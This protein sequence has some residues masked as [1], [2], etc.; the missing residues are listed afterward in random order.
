MGKEKVEKLEDKN[1][2]SRSLSIRYSIFAIVIELKLVSFAKNHKRKK[3][4][5]S[6][7]NRWIFVYINILY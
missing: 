7:K 3:Y 1:E 4:Q 5:K 2:N 6:F